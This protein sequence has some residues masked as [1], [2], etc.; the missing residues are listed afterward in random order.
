M[1]IIE[2]LRCI[3][4]GMYIGF[5]A[6]WKVLG[7]KEAFESAIHQ[8]IAC[9]LGVP[10]IVVSAVAFLFSAAKIIYKIASN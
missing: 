3:A 2:V 10:V 7:V 1:I 9:G 5:V 8:V 4:Y 6:F